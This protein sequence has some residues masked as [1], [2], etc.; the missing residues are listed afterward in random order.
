MFR[1]KHTC[2][3]LI[4]CCELFV[5]EI[6][7]AKI[8]GLLGVF[9][10][11]LEAKSLFFLVISMQDSIQT[12][13]SVR[14]SCLIQKVPKRPDYSGAFLCSLVEVWGSLGFI[15]LCTVH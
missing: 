5:S 15:F 12:L 11:L 4:R 7:L 2:I 14:V 10:K 8:L 6:F 13:L 9:C 1:K 3:E